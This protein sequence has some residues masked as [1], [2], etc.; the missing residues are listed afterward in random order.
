MQEPE[1]YDE[2]ALTHNISLGRK[3]IDWENIENLDEKAETSNETNEFDWENFYD[4]LEEYDATQ[5]REEVQKEVRTNEALDRELRASQEA[6]SLGLIHGWNEKDIEPLTEVFIRYGWGPTKI[7]LDREMR[8]GLNPLELHSAFQLREVWESYP[9]F[10]MASKY[11][12]LSWPFAL[13]IVRCF[14]SAPS[15]EE[16]EVFLI[17]AFNYW[18]HKTTLKSGISGFAFFLYN[19][20][21]NSWYY[22][23]Y[24]PVIILEVFMTEDDD[25]REAA[26]DHLPIGRIL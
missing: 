21:N 26:L 18:K 23:L 3:D 11:P 8:F 12:T 16:I 1:L 15:R 2:E 14:S 22:S 9:E 4:D 10:G 6:I 20:L 17:D 19:L 25:S 7:A 24:S 13:R 5:V